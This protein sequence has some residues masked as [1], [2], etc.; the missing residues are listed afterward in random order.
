M[1]LLEPLKLMRLQGKER[2]LKARKKRGAEDQD[3]NDEKKN[4]EGRRRHEKMN[5]LPI[6]EAAVNLNIP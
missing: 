1:L 4:R 6:I 2:R 3:R 5:G